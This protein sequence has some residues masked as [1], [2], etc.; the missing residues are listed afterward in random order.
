MPEEMPSFPLREPVALA[1]LLVQAGLATSKS[2]ARRLVAQGGVQLDG[3]RLASA[4]Q[5]MDRPG[6]LQVGRRHFV[7]LE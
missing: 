6:V 4:E 3:E 2:A 5:L 1:D 7:R